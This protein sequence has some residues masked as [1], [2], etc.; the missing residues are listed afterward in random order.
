MSHCPLC[1]VSVYHSN[2]EQVLFPSLLVV[3]VAQPNKRHSPSLV[4]K[5]FNG[6]LKFFFFHIYSDI[7][8]GL[9][10]ISGVVP[11]PKFRSIDVIMTSYL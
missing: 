5:C 10:F 1:C 11:T 4:K 8:D 6:T 2:T 9:K 3:V 7:Q